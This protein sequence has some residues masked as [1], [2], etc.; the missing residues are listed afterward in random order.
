MG[1]GATLME[2]L[3]PYY[4]SMDWQPETFGHYVT[5]GDA[6]GWSR[7]YWNVRLDGPYSGQEEWEMTAN[8]P[9]PAIVNAIHDAVGVWIDELPQLPKKCSALETAVLK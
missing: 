6:R 9:G 8:A 4:P 5:A 3:F 7:L 1:A 2:N